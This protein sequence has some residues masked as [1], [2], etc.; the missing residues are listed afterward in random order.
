MLKPRRLDFHK[1]HILKYAEEIGSL[2]K[3]C[4]YFGVGRASFCRWRAA[5]EKSGEAG[6][7]K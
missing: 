1:L 2:I 7:T 3:A 4:R 5:Y 6:V